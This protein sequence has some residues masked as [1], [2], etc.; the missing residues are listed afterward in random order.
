MMAGPL[1]AD[2]P[3]PMIATKDIGAVAAE[4]LLRPDFTGQRTQEL[5]GPRDVTYAEAT[6][7]IGLAIGK[8]D[9]TYTQ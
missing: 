6:K 1:R 7:I 4:A 5:L 8:P 2:L 3:L 9:L